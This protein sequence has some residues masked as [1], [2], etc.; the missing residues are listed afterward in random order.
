[1]K[2][3]ESATPKMDALKSDL[4]SSSNLLNDTAKNTSSLETLMLESP[5]GKQ[6]IR[7]DGKSTKDNRYFQTCTVYEALLNNLLVFVT[8]F[9][10]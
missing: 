1:M 8:L 10:K 7:T 4:V 3:E 6:G 2:P 5:S 9:I